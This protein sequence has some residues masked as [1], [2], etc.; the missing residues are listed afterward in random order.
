VGLEPLSGRRDAGEA[1]RQLREAGYDGR[2]V[3]LIGTAEGTG[4]AVAT[5]VAADLFR[6]TGLNLDLAV[7]D[8]ASWIRRRTSREPLERGG[9]SAFCTVT[10]GF[11]MAD[12]ASHAA[13][14]GNGLGAWPGWPTIPRLEALRE[15]WLEAPDPAGQQRIAGEMQGAA[16]EE[17]PFVPLGAY[18]QNTALRRNLAGRVPGFPIFWNIGRT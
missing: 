10:P 17:L 1:Q 14:R 7:S 18:W 4:A 15:T 3:R 6:R 12:P 5:Q 2:P 13:L 9:W 11:E 8:L 16:M